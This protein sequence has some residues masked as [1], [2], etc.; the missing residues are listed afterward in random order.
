MGITESFSQILLYENTKRQMVNNFQND[1]GNLEQLASLDFLD[2]CL[3]VETGTRKT[4]TAKFIPKLS[5]RA[6]HPFA[7]LIVRN[8]RLLLSSPNCSVT[9]RSMH[10]CSHSKK[11]KFEAAGGRILFLDE[12]GELDLG[13]QA[14]L[15]KVAEEKCVTRVGRNRTRAARVSVSVTRVCPRN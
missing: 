13:L 9:R 1:L 4:H 3:L 8:F 2:L 15:L 10:R 6:S 11:S 5:P 12:I 7:S 14:K